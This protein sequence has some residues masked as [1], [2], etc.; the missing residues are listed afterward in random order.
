M[1]LTNSRKVVF[2]RIYKME[3]E[4][5][6]K[7]IRYLV[8]NSNED[9]MFRLTFCHESFLQRVINRAKS[10]LGVAET[11]A[12]AG[13]PISDPYLQFS[14]YDLYPAAA[15]ASPSASSR[16][17]LPNAYYDID[18]QNAMHVLSLE[19]QMEAGMRS[20]RRRCE[21]PVKVCHYYSKGYC[22][23]GSKCRYFH[24][25]LSGNEDSYYHNNYVVVR[26]RPLE[27]LEMEIVELLK[28]QGGTPIS[29]ASLPMIYYE[30]YGRNLQADGYL[31][32]S[33]R[34]GKPGFSLTKLLLNLNA[35]SVLDRFLIHLS[36]TCFFM[37]HFNSCGDLT[38]YNFFHF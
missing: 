31:T 8:I 10:E 19:D 36:L 23:H 16:A 22:K 17:L 38:C 4:Y 37:L 11:M 7:I 24:G 33:Q 26:G 2:E 21:F 27:K 14:S 32:E 34:H 12:A 1:D 25:P 3:P 15:A 18:L 9:E 30:K 29:I 6:I 13:V 20:N 28:S 35:I 5:A